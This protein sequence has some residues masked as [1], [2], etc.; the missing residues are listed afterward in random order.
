MIQLA[1]LHPTVRTMAEN[2][3]AWA[4]YYGLSP[5]ITSTFRT[6]AEQKKLC[7]DWEAGRSKWPAN[8]PG[9]S[10][11]QYGLAFDS[12]VPEEWFPAWSWLRRYAGFE[13]LANDKIHGQYP[14]WRDHV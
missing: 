7:E 2:A 12:W 5:V 9:D 1:G 6:W 4:N 14:N 8:R 3:I 10:A 11:H 13:V